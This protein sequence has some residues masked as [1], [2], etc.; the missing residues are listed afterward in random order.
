MTLKKLD[1]VI[2]ALEALGRPAPSKELVTATGY[3][4]QALY[5]YMQKLVDANR[6]YIAYKRIPEKGGP[7]NNFYLAGPAP[8]GYKA[9]LQE[10]SEEERKKRAEIRRTKMLVYSRNSKQRRRETAVPE[11]SEQELFIP[12]RQ[13][14]PTPL[15]APFE[16]LESVWHSIIKGEH[17]ATSAR[18]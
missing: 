5:R 18:R 10:A 13:Y 12:N 3:T 9:E 14:R 8:E 6:A 1:C 15:A 2:A 4:T 11:L 7:G 17:H 16:Q